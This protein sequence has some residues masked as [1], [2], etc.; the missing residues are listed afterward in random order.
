MPVIVSSTAAEKVVVV[1]IVGAEVVVGVAVGTEA[2]MVQV[3]EVAGEVAPAGLVEKVEVVEKVVLLA[4]VAEV[5]K[6][7]AAR[8]HRRPAEPGPTSVTTGEEAAPEVHSVVAVD[9]VLF[10]YRADRMRAYWRRSVSLHPR[11]VSNNNV[12]DAFPTIWILHQ[13]SGRE[14][15]H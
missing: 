13:E 4:A 1:V 3:A 10:E 5:L 15:K 6:A 14:K 12:G 8:H 11:V 2:V 9:W 7:A